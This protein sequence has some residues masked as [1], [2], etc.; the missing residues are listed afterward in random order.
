MDKDG[1]VYA[2]TGIGVQVFDERGASLGVIALPMA[3][4]NLAFAGP[5]RA[6]LYVVGR[7]FVYRIP[8]LTRGPKRRG[9]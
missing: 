4:Q 5:K 3:P 9:K 1:R 6:E 2:A 7:G 8:T